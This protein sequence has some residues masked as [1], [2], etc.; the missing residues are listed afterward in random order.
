MSSAHQREPH[1]RFISLPEGI[2][3][4]LDWQGDGLQM[5]L[6]HANGFCAG[7]YTPFV[8]HLYKKYHIFASDVRGHGDS[9]FPGTERIRNWEIFAADLRVIIEK[10][11]TPP[12]IGMGHSLGAVTTY[13][14]AAKYPHLFS[15]IIL[16]DPVIFP[17]QEIQRIS[18]N[19]KQ[20]LGNDSPLAKGARMRKRTFESKQAA[21]SRF[22]A[23]HKIFKTWSREFVEAYLECG[24]LVKD[25]K[26]A[27]LRC[28]PEL[29]AQIFESVPIN[30]W[31]YADKIA[32]PVLALRG[33]KSNTFVPEAA[34][35]LQDIIPGAAVITVPDAGHFV[36]MEKPE[37]CAAAI[38]E[39][40]DRTAR[41]V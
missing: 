37:E 36:P 32:C 27:I 38:A 1:K 22:A 5:H 35:N 2:Y 34:R 13:I 29:E 11:M 26:T 40:I 25:S 41:S 30:V 4:Y 18:L 16:L 6:L 33:E 9:I 14:A 24:L 28:D 15:C 12:V 7:T 8:K 21:L 20:G 19:R 39:F 23:G 3:H 31:D 17:R 10:A